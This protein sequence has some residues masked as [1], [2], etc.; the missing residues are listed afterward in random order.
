MSNRTIVALVTM[1]AILMLS[2]LF[3]CTPAES[4]ATPT[5]Q[6]MGL[7]LVYPD[8]ERDAASTR[9]AQ[10][11]ALAEKK[12]HAVIVQIGTVGNYKIFRVADKDACTVHYVYAYTMLGDTQVRTDSVT[13]PVPISCGSDVY[14]Q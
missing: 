12:E 14:R 7:E 8:Q 2:T 11:L 10:A 4:P 3:A 13:A 6:T 5:T 9:A 1:Y